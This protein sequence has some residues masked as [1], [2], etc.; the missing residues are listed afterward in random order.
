MLLSKFSIFISSYRFYETTLSDKNIIYKLKTSIFG[1][2]Y[3]DDY[4]IVYEI[5]DF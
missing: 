4:A 1:N 3:L 5:D 2:L